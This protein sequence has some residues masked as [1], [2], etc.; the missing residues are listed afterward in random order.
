MKFTCN[1]QVLAKA[2]NIVSKAVTSKTTIPILK[3]ILL[4]VSEGQL[5]LTASDLDLSIE[6]TVL[7]VNIEKEG[8]VVVLS[9]L[10]TDIIRKLPNEDILIHQNED[11][12]VLIKTSVSEFNIM[13]LSPDEFPS[14]G[15]VEEEYKLIFEKELLKD[16]IRKTVFSASID[17]S[18][19][20][21]TGVLIELE[22]NGTNMIALDGFRMAVVREDM[23]NQNKSRIIIP[24]KLLNEVNKIIIDSEGDENIEFILSKKKAAM[25]F[26]NTKVFIRLLDGEFIKYK[27]I[28]PKEVKSKISVNK[29]M[30]FESI[31]RAAILSREGKNNLIKFAFGESILTITSRSEEGNV[32]EEI[33][34]IREGN[35]IE[36]GFNSKYILD[37]LKAVE[38]E[39]LILELISSVKPCVI[40]PASGNKFEYL[41]LP[42]RIS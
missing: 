21:I 11:K 32:K 37:V 35:E 19:G 16:M 41:V 12:S 38:D 40:K 7:D 6:K 39:E 42:V 5:V 17:E 31:E 30:L 28:L 3:G 23:K 24:A 33:P 13:G 25:I 34:I 8:S 15:E 20:I 26:E 4:N 22:E 18:K 29:A 10:F 2:L 1:Q 14:S 36:I 9:K 27:D